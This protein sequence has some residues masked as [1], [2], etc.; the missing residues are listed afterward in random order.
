MDIYVARQPIFDQDQNIFA[1]ELLYRRGK[2]NS[3]G[4]NFNGDQ[5]TSEVIINSFLLIGIE[6]LT[7]GK[8]AFI[9]F[10]ENLLKQEIPTVFPKESIIVEILEDIE[11][12]EEII[13]SCKRLKE[14]GY[15]LALDD[16]VYHQKFDPL[17]D[18]ADIIKVDFLLSTPEERKSIVQLAQTRNIKFLAE[19]V[20]TREAFEEAVRLGYSFFQGYFFS[21]PVILSGKDIPR[22]NINSIQ[23]LEEI[24]KPDPDIAKIARWI[25]TDVSLSY[26]LLRLINSVAFQLKRRVTSVKQAIALLG[27]NEIRKWISLTLLQD[28]GQLKHEII[29]KDSMVRAKF[30]EFLASKTHLKH[31]SS[32]IFLMGMFSRIDVL[33]N[34]TL[35]DALHD[36][37][38]SDEIKQCLLGEPSIFS[39]I[40]ELMTAYET[41]E[42]EKY[43]FQSYKL[44]L[45]HQEIVPYYL[46]AVKWV[47]HIFDDSIQEKALQ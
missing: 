32:E 24:N 15:Q 9:N 2:V 46:Q 17:I 33:M 35:S 47:E 1:Y 13:Q 7:N 11:P 30:G 10:T 21:K 29:I 14:L 41:G 4:E 12:S 40:Y 25:E 6:E 42:W 43:E 45:D 16:F 36:L 3:S 28:T 18:L 20:E 38:I 22:H 8:P 31:R 26:K 39:D 44:N 5:A 34:C 23:I 19:K 37:P 27:L